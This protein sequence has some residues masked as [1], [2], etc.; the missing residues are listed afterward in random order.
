MNQTELIVE[1]YEIAD[2]LKQSIL[3][4]DVIEALDRLLSQ[5]ETR[6]LIETFNKYKATYEEALPMKKH[7]PGF[8]QIAQNFIESK[9]KLYTHKD[10][11]TYQ[12]KLSTLN[13]ALEDFSDGLNELLK[14]CYIDTVHSCKKV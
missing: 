4:K 2:E 9:T 12:Q 8:K 1:T 10:Y 6:N 7:Y 3:Y 14:S 11:I 5:E 13:H